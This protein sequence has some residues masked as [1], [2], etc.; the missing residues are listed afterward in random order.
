VKPKPSR[1]TIEVIARG[2]HRKALVSTSEAHLRDVVLAGQRI[3]LTVRKRCH[4]LLEDFVRRDPA[5]LSTGERQMLLDNLVALACGF[6]LNATIPS[7]VST[8]RYASDDPVATDPAALRA[9]WEGIGQ[10]AAAHQAPATLPA[11]ERTLIKQGGPG[12]YVRLRYDVAARGLAE[13]ARHAAA[14]LLAACDRLRECPECHQLFVANRRQE[15]H[16]TCARRARDA[17]RP[18][19]QPKSKKARR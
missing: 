18:S 10:L 6:G 17:R 14:E 19:R 1:R 8:I 15:R 7:T 11:A 13:A 16:P 3:G 12:P 5:E 2:Q 9:L 4:W